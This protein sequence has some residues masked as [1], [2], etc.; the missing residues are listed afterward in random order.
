[1]VPI[2]PLVYDENGQKV[3]LSVKDTVKNIKN[4][5]F[6]K[7]F[8]SGAKITGKMLLW[9][10]KQ[11]LS[12]MAVGVKGV[13]EGISSSGSAGGSSVGQSRSKP[14][15]VQASYID[16]RSYTV[17]S[18]PEKKRRPIWYIPSKEEEMMDNLQE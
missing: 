10:I 5:E 1:M 8:V 9:C 3:K 12:L 2:Q 18:P 4:S 6:T 13:G 16:N 15:R 7:I 14:R 17:I 11:V